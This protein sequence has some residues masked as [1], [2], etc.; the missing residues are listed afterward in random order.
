MIN[1]NT[2]SRVRATTTNNNNNG[3]A[4]QPRNIKRVFLCA[5]GMGL[6]HIDYQYC[7]LL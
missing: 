4:Y 2:N 1:E 6:Q 7:D 5:N 3:M